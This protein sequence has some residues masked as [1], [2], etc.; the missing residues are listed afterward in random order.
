MILIDW[1]TPGESIASEWQCCLGC[2]WLHDLAFSVGDAPLLR[3]RC[4]VA[5]VVLH[6]QARG[7]LR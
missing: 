6:P 3:I 7:F 1:W 2:S 5:L 4:N